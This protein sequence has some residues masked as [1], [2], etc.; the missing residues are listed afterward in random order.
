MLGISWQTLRARRGSLAGAFV[1]IWLAVTLA[2]ATGLLMSGALGAPGPGRLA[3]ADAVVRADPTITVGKGDAAEGLDVVPAP[4][5][6]AAAVDRAASVPGVERAVGDIAFPAG[7]WDARGRRLV[8]AGAERVQGHGWDSAVLTPYRLRDG[9]APAAPHDVVAD[10][11]F[12]VRVGEVVRI[13]TPEGDSRY[14]ISGLADGHASLD[15]GQAALF[16]APDVAAALSGTPGRVNAIGILAANGQP[17]PELGERLGPGVEVLDAGHAANADAGDPQASDRESLI[18][19]FGVMGGI[20]G[21]VAL[22]VVAGTFA[23]AIAQ[24]RRETAVLRALGATP[25]QVRRLIAGEALIVS[26]VA[27]ALGVLAG[28]PLA[29]AIVQA[30]ADHGAAPQGF[31]PGDS[32]IPLVAAIGG[33]VGVAQL[34]VVA[35][36][37]RAGRVRPAEALREV[38]I[39]HGRPGLIQLLSGV[40]CLGGGVAMAML[41]DGELALAFA[42]LAGILLATGTALLGRWLLGLPAAVLSLPLRLL[43]A[44]GLL[45]ST[46]LAA[47]RWRTAALAT[48]IVLIAMLVGTQGVLQHSSQRDTEQVTAAR[49]TAD[50]VVVGRDGAPLPSGTAGEIEHLAGVDAVTGMATT[51]LVLPGTGLGFGNPWPA[52]GLSADAGLDLGVTSGSLRDVGGS[53]VAVSQVAATEGHLELGETFD[54]RM[55]DTRPATL[56]VA[57]VYERSAGLGD[58]VLDTDVVRRHATLGTDEAVFVSGGPAARRSLAGYAAAHPGVNALTRSQYLATVRSASNADAWGVWL[59]VALSVTFAALALINTAAMATG[60]RRAELATIRLLGGTPGQATRMIALELAPTLAVALVAG[61]AIAGLAMYGVPHGVRGIPIVVPAAIV[62]GLLAGATGLAL[63]AGAVAA[64]FALRASPA[65]A[66]RT[67]E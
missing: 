4:R 30:L 45:A 53:A 50:H 6:P 42:I 3:A 41:F 11:R 37:R 20:S 25:R 63:A 65:A 66:M 61:A 15:R 12:G 23:L 34:A 44:P 14:R 22:F 1:A 40:L 33:G 62:A 60:E 52:A 2:Y 5:L 36:A 56:R 7:A 38:A 18:A 51:Q 64:R 19:I 31:E 54:A 49:V 32:W 21:A 43:G 13:V 16:F 27:T 58:V 35:A 59:I 55:A 39:E 17:L 47:N 57:A 10:V 8:A 9:R 24:R 29:S 26:V 67:L 28:R 46:S 48:P